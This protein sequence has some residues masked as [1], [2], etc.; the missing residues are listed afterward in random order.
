MKGTGRQWR[1]AALF[2]D[3][4]WDGTLV[5]LQV[6]KLEG[7]VRLGPPGLALKGEEGKKKGGGERQGEKEGCLGS[8]FQPNPGAIVHFS[9]CHPVWSGGNAAKGVFPHTDM[10]YIRTLS[11]LTGR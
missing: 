1:I 3:M 7:Q 2:E 8:H 5:N 4:W 11:V 10:E 9:T 6:T